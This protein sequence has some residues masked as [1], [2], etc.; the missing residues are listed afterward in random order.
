MSIPAIKIPGVMEK[1]DLTIVEPLSK[2]L[3]DA[4]DKIK[5]GTKVLMEEKVPRWRKIYNGE[6]W[7]EVKSFPWPK[8]SNFVVQLVGIHVDTLV[9]RLHGVI[10]QT[11]PV[12]TISSFTNKLPKNYKRSLEDLFQ[13]TS[14]EETEL[15][16]MTVAEEWLYDIVKLGSSVLKVPYVEEVE[17][18]VEMQNMQLHIVPKLKVAGPRPIKIPFTHFGFWPLN[19]ANLEDTVLKY[20]EFT[21]EKEIL[22]RYKASGWYTNIDTVLQKAPDR[23]TP[24]KG[25]KEQE[26]AL[27]QHSTQ[28][29]GYT[30]FECW[31][32]WQFGGQYVDCIIT[33]HKDS[34]TIVRAI[35]NPYCTGD[36]YSDVFVP[37]RLFPRDDLWY[38]RGYAE[39]LEQAQEEASTIH[40]QRRDASTA[41]NTNIIKV[42]K[43]STLDIT[44]PL[45]PMK[46]VYIDEMDDLQVE[47]LGRP[48][49]FNVEEEKMS[50]DL[51]ERRSGVSPP[52]I[53]FGAGYTNSKRGIYNTGGTV[54]ML[55]EGNTRQDMPLLNVRSALTR[56]GNIIL[57]T[58]A[59]GGMSPRLLLKYQDRMQII[60]QA[61]KMYPS[62]SAQLTASTSQ[63][64]KQ[65]EQSQ[66]MQIAQV[67]ANYYQQITQLMGSIQQYASNPMM[68]Q[69]LMVI[70]NSA[71]TLMENILGGTLAYGDTQRLL[72]PEL[73]D[74][75]EQP[76][77]VS[78]GPQGVSGQPI[79]F[80]GVG[81][82]TPA[83]LPAGPSAPA[84]ADVPAG[85]IA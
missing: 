84:E 65:V 33:I 49:V 82:N 48:N 9:A 60:G 25:V 40:N 69:F 61:L 83:A 43:G 23:T 37:G 79:P 10:F 42:K 68:Q 30:F 67:M 2:Y 22:E 39:M 70:Y 58:Y 62:I 59:M 44:F 11:D 51:A 63:M 47:Q 16:L 66:N 34:K 36:G 76:P 18:A 71:R 1:P 41:S 73:P 78:G 7:E 24:E 32:K 26:D 31:C 19:V 57:K 29:A 27:G 6:P 85:A 64:N 77:A 55:Q 28:L 4:I 35:F 54:S 80:P 75:R 15:N 14:L 46:P 38:G 5:Q 12:F 3:V 72:P 8:A 21:L 45:F 13:Y 17:N 74:P 56:A 52:M 50:L 20:H 81:G 53:G